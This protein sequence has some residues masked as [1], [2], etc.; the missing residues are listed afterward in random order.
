MNEEK[1]LREDIADV[2][3]MVKAI[4]AKLNDIEIEMRK[5]SL[6]TVMMHDERWNDMRHPTEVQK[7]D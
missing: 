7:N 1:T 5:H 2:K 3:K 6:E 4:A